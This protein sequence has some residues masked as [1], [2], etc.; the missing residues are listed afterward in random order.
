MWGGIV[1]SSKENLCNE[2]IIIKEL[3]RGEATV[4][5]DAMVHLLGTLDLS[6]TILEVLSDCCI[7]TPFML[8][9]AHHA[10]LTN[11]LQAEAEQLL[12]TVGA[13]IAM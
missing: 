13:L 10:L 4:F 1:S 7:K 2:T 12:N 8:A 9:H 6:S 11:G 5:V 3:P